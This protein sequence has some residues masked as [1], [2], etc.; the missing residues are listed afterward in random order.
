MGNSGSTNIP[1]GGSDGYHVLRVS[2]FYHFFLDFESSE[3]ISL[4]NSMRSGLIL[5]KIDYLILYE[6]GIRE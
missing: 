3:V 6:S 4:L 1:G 2:L 5:V